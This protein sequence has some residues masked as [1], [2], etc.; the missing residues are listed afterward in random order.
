MI[1]EKCK[2]NN[3]GYCKKF[4]KWKRIEYITGS[5]AYV[6]LLQCRKYEYENNIH[7]HNVKEP[8]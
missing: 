1:C 5:G 3:L 6:R 8:E 4:K 7:P 2:H